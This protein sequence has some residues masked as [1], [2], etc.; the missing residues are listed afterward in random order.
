MSWAY[1]DGDPEQQ[2]RDEDGQRGKPVYAAVG[3]GRKDVLLGDELEGIGYG[4]ECAVRTDAHRAHALLDAREGLSF[5]PG[6]NQHHD[7]KEGKHEGSADGVGNW[8]WDVLEEFCHLSTSPSTM[9]REPRM[10]TASAT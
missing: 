6:Q 4:L 10:T 5:E 8:L 2:G 9:S 3:P 1:G 7:R